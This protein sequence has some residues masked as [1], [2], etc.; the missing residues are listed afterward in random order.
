M[1]KPNEHMPG[2]GSRTRRLPAFLA[3][4]VAGTIAAGCDLEVFSPATVD[5]E[6]LDDFNAIEALWSG[7][8]GQT[9]H[10]AAGR[11]GPGGF[12][13]F[14]ALRTDETVH[15]GHPGQWPFLRAASDGEPINPSWDEVE[16]LWGQAMMTRYVADA[17]VRQAAEIYANF[18]DSD[19][20]QVR[21]IVRRDRMRTHAWAG[22]AYRVL[23]DNLCNAVIDG[24]PLESHTV[25]YERGLDLVTQGIEFADAEG[26]TDVDETGVVAAYAA[27]AQL[28]ML[29]GDWEGAVADAGQV[30][31]GF[32]GLQ[33][34]FTTVEPDRRQQYWLRF[35]DFFDEPFAGADGVGGGR[36]MTLWGTPFLDWGYNTTLDEGED[37]RV[38]YSGPHATSANPHRAWGGD[39]RRIWRR[40]IKE[41]ATTGAGLVYMATGREMRLIEAEARLRAGDW[42]G[43]VDKINELRE[44]W[45][46]TT[47]GRFERDGHPLPMVE[48]ASHEEAWDLLKRERGIE[49]W[50]EGRRM[51]D[52]RRWEADPSVPSMATTV[53]R[54]AVGAEPED[55]PR[56]VV[57]DI[58]GDFCVP[59]GATEA[60]LNPNL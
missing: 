12:F 2:A 58:P 1:T 32:N 16:E 19:R 15:S 34:G 9:A 54:E 33:L 52:I 47:G 30:Q 57:T 26:I 13:T 50:L 7:I 29:L 37:M 46:A 31:T 10:I 59:V 45:N 35:I 22:L 6:T 42:A 51:A 18:R 49:M 38:P 55:D 41:T 5:E 20:S 8:M 53:V 48:A 24:G 17:G 43:A 3:V 60:R 36:N 25:Y 21:E 4:A 23:G 44:W 11:P 28:R 56:R 27:R 14:G 40:Q 39:A